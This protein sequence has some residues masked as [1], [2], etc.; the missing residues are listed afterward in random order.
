M[1]FLMLVFFYIIESVDV[2]TMH[3]FDTWGKI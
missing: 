1:R 3:D 2:F